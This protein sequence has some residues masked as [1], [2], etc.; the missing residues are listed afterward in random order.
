MLSDLTQPMTTGGFLRNAWYMA[1][2]VDDFCQ[3]PL[4][5]RTMLDEPIVFFKTG[6]GQWVA[7]E[8][9]CAHRFAPLSQGHLLEGCRVQCPYHGLEY[10]AT[11]ACVNNPHGAGRIPPSARVKV[12][13]VVERHRALW[14][15]MGDQTP[16]SDAIPDYSILDHA[17]T[18]HST[19]LDY[20]SIRANYRLIIDNLLDLSHTSYL[21]E[22]L[23]GNADTVRSD[24]QCEV[25][26][27]D[28]IVTRHARDASAPAIFAQCWPDHPP[29]VDKVTRMRWMAPSSLRLLSCIC[30][31]GSDPMT[32]TGFHALH[33][34][35][36]ESAHTTH[37]FF[38]AVRFG[39][40]TDDLALDLELQEKIARMRRF[41]FEEQD[42]PVIEAQ[43]R[44]LDR[45]NRVLEPVL[46]EIDVGPARYRRILAQRI[47]AERRSLIRPVVAR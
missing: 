44:Y 7:L 5:H 13:P 41:A 20:L 30:E 43:Q 23:I 15:W 29:R 22:G 47:E 24:T 34:L 45:A 39:V 40:K 10:D 11:G 21:H 26:G 37:Y 17:P 1:G 27:S 31:P 3:A 35:T 16:Q 38:T 8:D 4:T 18:L 33:M 36:P 19:R 25:E 2:W 6:S 12:W 46:L 28:V 14:V 9:R 32:G 42:A